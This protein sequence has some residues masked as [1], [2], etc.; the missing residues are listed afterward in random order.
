M[1]SPKTNLGM[2]VVGLLFFAVA[3]WEF[4]S[5]DSWIVWILLG[6]LFGGVGA[7]RQLLTKDD[8]A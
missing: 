3:V 2:G 7:M 4:L 6:V 5:G 8:E 1:A